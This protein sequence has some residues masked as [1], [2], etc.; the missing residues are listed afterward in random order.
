MSDIY[1]TT[2]DGTKIKIKD[3]SDSHLVNTLKWM[4]RNEGYNVEITQPWGG[5][6]D[7]YF[8][9]WSDTPEYR[10]MKKEVENRLYQKLLEK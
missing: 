10:A 4:D 1:W 6:P 8:Q 9:S 3:M 5:C 2:R 7:V